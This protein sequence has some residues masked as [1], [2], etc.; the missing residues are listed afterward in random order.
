MSTTTA[1][2]AVLCAVAL[3]A[4]FTAGYLACWWRNRPLI[5]RLTAT[6]AAHR[7]TPTGPTTA[8]EHHAAT[9]AWRARQIARVTEFDI[10]QGRR[11]AA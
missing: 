9:E 10:A 8:A 4:M 3:A 2:V 1:L 7:A 11:A 6:A 5:N